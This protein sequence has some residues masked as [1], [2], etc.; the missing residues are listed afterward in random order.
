MEYEKPE[1][2]TLGNEVSPLGA[3]LYVETVIYGI[4]FAVLTILIS[5]IDFTP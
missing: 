4:G 5:Q 1:V 2:K 3:F